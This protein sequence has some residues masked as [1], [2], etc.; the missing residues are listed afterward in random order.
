MLQSKLSQYYTQQSQYLFARLYKNSAI[1]EMAA[2]CCKI[3]TFAFQCRYVPLFN[4][5]FSQ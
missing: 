4:A 3:Q 5:F 2:Q 1:A